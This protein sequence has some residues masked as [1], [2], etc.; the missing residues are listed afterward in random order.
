MDD[1]LEVLLSMTEPV[2]L[3]FLYDQ[4][5]SCYNFYDEFSNLKNFMTSRKIVNIKL[6][7]K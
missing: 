6:K 3:L 2:F 1:W 5:G 4:R 7:K